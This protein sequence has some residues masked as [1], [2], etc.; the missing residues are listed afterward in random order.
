MIG[1]LDDSITN[2]LPELSKRDSRFEKITIRHLLAM[3]SGLRWERSDSNPMSDDFL[4]YYSPDLRQTALES[5]IVEAPGQTFQ[6]NDY[7]PVLIG[8][9]LERAT[10]ISVSEYMETRLWQPMGAE[11]DGS[12]SLDSERSGFEK[13]FVGVNGRAIDLVKLGW[14]FLNEGKN[15]AIQVVPNDW[16]Q[17]VAE[18]SNAIPTNRGTHSEYYQ[19]Y[20]W[21]D[22]ENDAY[23]AE[24]DKCQFIYVYPKSDLVLARFGTDCGDY[25]FG[26]GWM[27]GVAQY[28]ETQLKQ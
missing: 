3:T 5:E 2:Y 21:L 4:T 19:Y 18:G 17:Q 6:Y 28:L 16:V 22:A 8:M 26:I 11:G 13:M 25:V 24:G 1:S 20:W 7:N 10:G 23:Y 14:L 9:I 27:V 12:W 15:G